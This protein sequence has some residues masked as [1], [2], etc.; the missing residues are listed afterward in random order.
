VRITILYDNTTRDPSLTAD[1]GFAC[2]VERE[3]GPTILFDTG[4]DG[5]ILLANMAALGIEPETVEAVFISHG[6]GD[7]VGG[8]DAVLAENDQV[9]LY[10]PP[11]FVPPSDAFETVAVERATELHPG[12]YSTGEL[13]GIEQALVVATERGLVIIV[14]C[15]HPPMAQILGTAAQFGE[16]YGIVGGLHGTRPL[17]LAGLELICATHCTQQMAAIRQQYPAQFEAGGVGTVLEI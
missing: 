1:W 9:T 15:S 12:I 10:H 11:A 7:H 13:D 8:L 2:L 14:G 17:A 16:L 3:S 6:H 4:A 5:E